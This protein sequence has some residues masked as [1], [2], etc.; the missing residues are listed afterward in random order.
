MCFTAM[1][2]KAQEINSMTEPDYS[3]L[4]LLKDELMEEFTVLE[5]ELNSFRGDHINVSK[6]EQPGV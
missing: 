1:A 2:R 5:K 4:F 3:R 6:P